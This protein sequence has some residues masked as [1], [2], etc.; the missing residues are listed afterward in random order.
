MRGPAHRC[1]GTCTL[2]GSWKRP[3]ATQRHPLTGALLLHRRHVPTLRRKMFPTCMRS[4]LDVHLGRAPKVMHLT[5]VASSGTG[6]LRSWL[7]RWAARRGA[8][9]TGTCHSIRRAASVTWSFSLACAALS[10]TR[11]RTARPRCRSAYAIRPA[12]VQLSSS[13][14]GGRTR[15]LRRRAAVSALKTAR[16]WT[17][18]AAVTLVRTHQDLYPRHLGGLAHAEF[19]PRT[20][21]GSLLHGVCL[22]ELRWHFCVLAGAIIVKAPTRSRQPACQSSAYPMSSRAYSLNCVPTPRTSFSDEVGLQLYISLQCYLLLPSAQAKQ[23]G[24]CTHY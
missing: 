18:T 21:S 5:G 10:L 19:K 24:P 13:S 11:G 1:H 12:S 20:P 17:W 6:L 8:S 2:L 16:R 7:T 14:C 9:A 3:A 22:A 15:L 4:F 23:A